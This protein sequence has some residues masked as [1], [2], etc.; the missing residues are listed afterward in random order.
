[1]ACELCEKRR[2]RRYCPGI[3]GEICPI[4]CGTHRE[5]TVHCPLEC[6][7]LQ[8]ARKHE[9]PPA[10]DPDNLP[11]R[12]IRVSESFLREREEL[13][14][15]AGRTIRDAALTMQDAVDL[16][17]REALEALVQTYKTME[18]GLLYETR[19]SNLL[20]AAI[21]QRFRQQLAEFLRQRKERLGME[22][23]RDADVLGVLVFLQRL[24][25]LNNN[26]RKWGRAFLGFLLQQI[27]DTI[28]SDGVSRRV[29]GPDAQL[30]V[31]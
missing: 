3:R 27:P 14:V 4:C 19:P 16:D 6:V 1:M 7:Y 13:F 18:S 22:T 17:V 24:E 11:N 23:I 25:Y 15:F 26:G 21:C 9:K 28:E 29:A 2:P 30:I 31:P 8:D 5:E 20:A 10:A 12:D